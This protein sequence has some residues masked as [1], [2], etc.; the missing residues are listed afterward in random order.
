MNSR[1][2]GCCKSQPQVGILGG[3]YCEKDCRKDWLPIISTCLRRLGQL[4]SLI[5]R[6]SP[7]LF[8][9]PRWR[10]CCRQC[11]CVAVVTSFLFTHLSLV[12][13]SAKCAF[14]LSVFEVLGMWPGPV[15]LTVTHPRSLF[16]SLE[17]VFVSVWVILPGRFS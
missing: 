16:L 13:C 2:S 11:S 9:C 7:V 14:S 1:F 5:V 6:C 12:A 15:E 10:S 8:C 3:A 4:M 17:S